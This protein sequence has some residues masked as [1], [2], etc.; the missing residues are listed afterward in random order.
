M[1]RNEYCWNAGTEK[2]W[3]QTISI[4]IL[5]LM[6]IHLVTAIKCIPYC[7]PSWT[8]FTRL[9]QCC[10]KTATRIGQVLLTG[11]SYP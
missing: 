7:V 3:N 2:R 5:V 4:Y 8:F 9:V 11:L 10:T 6:Y 1:G